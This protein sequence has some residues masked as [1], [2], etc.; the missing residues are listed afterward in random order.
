MGEEPRR[1]CRRRAV[2]RR[3]TITRRSA[4]SSASARAS[5]GTGRSSVGRRVNP[6]RLSLS[7]AAGSANAR[8]DSGKW[9]R[10]ANDLLIDMST[11]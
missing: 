7:M 1:A 5:G 11:C 2:A 6:S 4:R 3:T 8:T 10:R 9:F